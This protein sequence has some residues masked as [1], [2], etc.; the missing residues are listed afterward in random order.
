VVRKNLFII[1]GSVEKG[2]TKPASSHELST[3]PHKV[4]REITHI[5]WLFV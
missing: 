1:L 3:A 4:A 2:Q 5:C